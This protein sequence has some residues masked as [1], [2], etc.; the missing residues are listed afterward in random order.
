MHR[1]GFGI[2]GAIDQ[3]FDPGVHQ[4]TRAHCARFNCSKQ[5]AVPKAVVA[6]SGTGFAQGNDF[7]V[8]SG[9]G[10]GTGTSPASRA[11][12]A[13][14]RASSIQSSSEAVV[15]RLSLIVSQ[16][17]HCRV[18][19]IL[20]RRAMQ[21]SAAGAKGCDSRSAS[22]GRQMTCKTV[23][24]TSGT[25]RRITVGTITVIMSCAVTM[26]GIARPT[27]AIVGI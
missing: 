16:C 24:T 21:D 10:V 18:Q 12:W 23:R 19:V 25:T 9:I 3:P 8:G 2:V 27:Q 17:R 1:A 15:G 6:Q 4:R 26:I 5:F 20:A 22:I 13:A 14:R 11:R 7:G